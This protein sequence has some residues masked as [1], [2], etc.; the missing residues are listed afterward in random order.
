MGV[1]W[2]FL[3]HFSSPDEEIGPGVMTFRKPEVVRIA[4]NF[5]VDSQYN[6]EVQQQCIGSFH[7]GRKACPPA[8]FQ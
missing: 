6:N 5:I 7:T 8:A 3:G 1:S 2:A 4:D